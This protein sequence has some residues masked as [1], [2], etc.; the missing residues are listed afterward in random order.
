[1]RARHGEMVGGCR[2]VRDNKRQNEREQGKNEEEKP[3]V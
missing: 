3:D 1:M 2:A